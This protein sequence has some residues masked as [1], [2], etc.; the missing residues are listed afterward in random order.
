MIRTFLLAIAFCGLAQ[1]QAAKGE[2]VFVQSCSTGY[3]HGARGVGA[4]APRLA[5]RGFDQ[6]F[7]R[8]TIANGIAGTSMP[9][10]AKSLSRTDLTAVIAYVAGL[11]GATQ[12]AAEAA[13]A[14]LTPQAT[15]GQELFRDSLKSFGRCSTCHQL[16][17]FGIAVAPPIHDVPLNVAGLKS[18]KTPR[19]VTASVAGE[20]MPA[21]VV[22]RKTGSVTF[23]D[24]TSP[25]PVLRTVTPADFTS[26]DGSAWLHS[27]VIGAYT[28][29]DL[30]S[31][32]VYLRAAK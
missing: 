2:Q 19:L 14:K 25:P 7:I 15:R 17:G 27:S 21:L 32:L 10:F 31:I 12:T 16:G 29:A 23:Y 20:S 1:A 22:A 26:Q 28:D 9:A 13:P 5:A 6:N 11:N 4:G 24:L 3:C 30:T 8:N 18:L